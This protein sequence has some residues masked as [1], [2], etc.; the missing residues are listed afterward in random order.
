MGSRCGDGPSQC[1]GE[2][3]FGSSTLWKWAHRAKRSAPHRALNHLV[4]E[5]KRHKKA[6]FFV[7]G[8]AVIAALAIAFVAQTTHRFARDFA[9]F[10]STGDPGMDT[11]TNE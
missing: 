3:R 5:F 2:A 11:I 10:E 9:F 6:T 4:S 8:A 1:N 7:L